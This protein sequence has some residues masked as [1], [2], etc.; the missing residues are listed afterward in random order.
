ME[1]LRI[2]ILRETKNP[3]DRRVPFTPLQCR[4][5]QDSHIGLEILVQ[6]SD[7]RCFSNEEYLSEG[8]TLSEDLSS[9]KVL[10]GVKEV[11]EETFLAGKTYFFFSHTAKKQPYNR[12]LLQA[13]VRLG[14]RL[15]DYEY[16]TSENG[17]RVVAFGRW[18]G[19]VGAYNGLRARGE[20]SGAFSL[21]PAFACRDLEEVQEELKQ[22][23]LG[24]ARIAVTGGGR[25]A[26]GA[27]EILK[28]AGVKEISPDDYLSSSYDLPVFTRLDPW[29]YTRRK[30][31]SDFDFNHFMEHPEEY[32]NQFT[33]YA[34]RTD[35]FVACHFWD[36]A[37]P[38]MLSRDDLA[39][40]D[41]PISL[42]ADI[43]CDIKGPIAST[44]RAS[45]I[46]LPY[47]GYDPQT[48]QEVLPF[49]KDS[50]TVMAV[51]NLPGE[52]PRDASAD[53]GSAL[54]EQVLPEL[55]GEKDT[56]MLARASIA[57]AGSLTSH[58]AYLSDY[59]AGRE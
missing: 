15:I 33:P 44:I 5:L 34:K 32:E 18:A 19:V 35:I 21:K 30:D 9:C 10:M 7:Y 17:I 49:K 29:H 13:V 8:L 46:A 24:S 27:V 41:I 26:G 31:G 54:M 28:H 39:G 16:L 2:G 20:Q 48:D 37:S 51:D 36:P 12:D 47:Y 53:F 4:N 25:V 57:E 45:T 23:V 52:L 11:K 42:V 3:P 6:P 50:I 56:G 58:Y 59:L 14:I 55:L 43:S 22:V 1:K 40:G 38:V